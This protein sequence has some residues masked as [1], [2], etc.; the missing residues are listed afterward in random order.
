[1]P[2]EEQRVQ[3]PEAPLHLRAPPIDLGEEAIGVVRRLALAAAEE[4]EKQRA[5][6]H[7]VLH[8]RVSRMK[9]TEKTAR[10]AASIRLSAAASPRL[11]PRELPKPYW[12]ISS[13]TVSVELT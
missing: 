7:V 2:D 3:R 5:R 13:S 9:T 8:E 12:S 11:P 10:K 1:Q 6:V 4:E